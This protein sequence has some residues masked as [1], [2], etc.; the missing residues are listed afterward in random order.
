MNSNR[1]SFSKLLTEHQDSPYDPEKREFIEDIASALY[2]R[3]EDL[4]SICDWPAV[5]RY[6]FAC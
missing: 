4:P 2:E 1:C 5:V 6:F 3:Y